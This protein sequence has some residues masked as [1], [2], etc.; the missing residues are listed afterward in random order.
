MKGYPKLRQQICCLICCLMLTA[1]AT[2]TPAVQTPTDAPVEVSVTEVFA[3]DQITAEP[4]TP[5]PTPEPTPEP[6]PAPTPEPTPTP[7]PE[8]MHITEEMLEEGAFDSYFDDTVFVGDSL[9][10]S[11]SNLVREKR[12]R[13]GSY[14]GEAQF[15]GTISMSVKIA[16]MN[17][18]DPGK[19]TFSFRGHAVSVTD[20]I[21]ATGAKK[22]F[23]LLG[24]ND[25]GYRKWEV[26][27][28]DYAKLIETILAECP[29]TRIIVLGV[30]PVTAQFCKN[31]NVTIEKWNTFN[32]SL[33]AICDAHDVTFYTFAQDFMD[34]KGYLKTEYAEGSFHLQEKGELVWIRAMRIFAAKELYPDAIFETP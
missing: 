30:L 8:P 25:L 18:A 26:V 13:Y 24:T 29:D 27:E 34:D 15:L 19:V 16:S 31:N 22:A 7:T 12:Q 9:T 14:L 23:I 32:D 2:A 21:N 1:C 5:V 28:Q 6:T 17:K 33:K 10:R 11:L 4:V 20:G 3:V